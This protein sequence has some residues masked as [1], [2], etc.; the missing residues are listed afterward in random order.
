M[1]L[2]YIAILAFLMALFG[3]TLI[4]TLIMLVAIFYERDEWLGRQTIQAFLLCVVSALLPN[5]FQ[6]TLSSLGLYAITTAISVAAFVLWLLSAIFSIIAIARCLREQDADIPIASSFA[7]KAYGFLKPT[8][9]PPQNTYIPHP[10]MQNQAPQASQPQQ[11]APPVESQ[12]PD[13]QSNPP[14][15]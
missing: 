13:Q 5:L 1:C 6:L 15:A 11:P 3:Q 2:A 9:I 12:T 8:F 7:Y 14:Q 10:P 4:C